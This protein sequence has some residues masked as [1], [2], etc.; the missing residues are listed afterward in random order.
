MPTPLVVEALGMSRLRFVNARTETEASAGKKYSVEPEVSN[1]SPADGI[2]QENRKSEEEEGN[3]YL[4][5]T[6]D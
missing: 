5:I 6:S 1:S 4:G 2:R 3:L